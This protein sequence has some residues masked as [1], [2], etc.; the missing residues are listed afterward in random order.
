MKVAGLNVDGK[1]KKKVVREVIKLYNDN[2][3]DHINENAV[4]DV[5]IVKSRQPNGKRSMVIAE[6]RTVELK[7]SFNMLGKKIH[8]T[9]NDIFVGD[10]LTVGQRKLLYELKQRTDLFGKVLFRDGTVRCA[11]K[12]GGWRQFCYL[13]ELC[14]LPPASRDNPNQAT[15]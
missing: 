11:K 7:R 12:D 10:D 6:M 8:E 9:N 3:S 13:N 1:T 5:Q 15:G 14:N 2:S 4:Y